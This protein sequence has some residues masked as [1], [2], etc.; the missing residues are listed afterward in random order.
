MLMAHGTGKSPIFS[1]KT[2][3]SKGLTTTIS[4]EV[5]KPSRTIL[6]PTSLLRL[7]EALLKL[8]IQ[9][10]VWILCSSNS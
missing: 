5:T 9:I 8:K 3:I 4:K 10:Q 2:T 6:K 7:K 1:T